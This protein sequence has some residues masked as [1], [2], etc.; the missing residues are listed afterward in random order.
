MDDLPLEQHSKELTVHAQAVEDGD[1]GF[2]SQPVYGK[3]YNPDHDKK[4][5]DR[6]GRKQELKRR[7]RYCE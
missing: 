1:N 7:F 5:M 4:D 6:L 2:A 3:D